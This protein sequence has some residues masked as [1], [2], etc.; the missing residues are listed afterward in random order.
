MDMDDAAF[1]KALI[2]AAFALGGETGWSRVSVAGAARRAAL[3]L[4][5][6]RERFPSRAA[7][8]LRFGRMA[9]MAALA[10]PPAEGTVRD[11]LFYLLMQRIDVMQEHRTGVLALMRRLPSDPALALLLNCATRRSMRWLLEAAGVSADGVRGRLRV[12]GMVGIWLL[13]L[14]AWAADQSSDISATMSAVDSALQRAERLALWLGDSARPVAEQPGAPATEEE[15]PAP[16]SP[17]PPAP[18]PPELP[19]A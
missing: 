13:G 16:E 3:P 8:L 17:P 18:L 6:A 10:N 1:D 15:P 14:R 7:I 11:R 19:V 12:R 9:D 5:R 2:G 4:A